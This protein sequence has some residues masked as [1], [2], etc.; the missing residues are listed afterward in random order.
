MVI[1]CRI[2][3]PDDALRKENRVLGSCLLFLPP[4]RLQRVLEDAQHA[5]GAEHRLIPLTVPANAVA[6]LY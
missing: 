4:C 2:I 1:V 3:R 5:I 6:I